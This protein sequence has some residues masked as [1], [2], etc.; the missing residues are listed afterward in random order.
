MTQGDEFLKGVGM[1]G[2]TQEELLRLQ[3]Q[4]MQAE[5][6]FEQQ[7]RLAGM[8]PSMRNANPPA[9]TPASHIRNALT[10]LNV[11][12]EPKTVIR[13]DRTAEYLVLVYPA[14]LDAVRVRLMAALA[15]LEAK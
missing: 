5:S 6:P 15:L 3:G 9:D 8:A 12:H 4:G 1:Q 13:S 11:W 14:D 7:R 10:I 2:M